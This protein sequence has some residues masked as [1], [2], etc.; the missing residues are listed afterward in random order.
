MLCPQLG[1]QLGILHPKLP[2]SAPPFDNLKLESAFIQPG[3]VSCSWVRISVL[4]RSPHP[5]DGCAKGALSST[6]Q[7]DSEKQ[8]K[9]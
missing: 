5:G 1:Y 7:E 4:L 9:E 2:A 6:Q 3:E 8:V